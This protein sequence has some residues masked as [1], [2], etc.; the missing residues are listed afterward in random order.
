MTSIRLAALAVFAFVT[1][2]GWSCKHDKAE[3]RGFRTVWAIKPSLKFEICNMIGILIG[4]ETELRA[5]PQIHREWQAN[6]PVE[7]RAALQTI[8]RIIGPNWP[9]GP[10]LSLLWANLPEV[11]SLHTL[12]VNIRP[13]TAV[14]EALMASDYGSERNW[15]QWLELKPHVEVVVQ[16]LATTRFDSYWRARILPSLAGRIATLKQELQAY[17]LVGDIQRF[18]RD[19]T[20]ARDTITVYVLALA[21][22]HELRLRSQS[23]YTDAQFSARPLVRSFYQEM[24]H[25]YCDAL[26]DSVFR[27]EFAAL[28][29]DPF[30]QEAWRNTTNNGATANF[31]EFLKKEIVL[32][33]TLWLAE[34]RQLLTTVESGYAYEAGVVVRNYLRPKGPKVHAVAGVLYSYLE[35][36]LKIER[37]SYAGFIKD[38]F[39]TGRLQPGKIASRYEEFITTSLPEN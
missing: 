25:P 22:P 23:R 19:Y 14:R 3:P 10:R 31:S 5:H 27:E 32:A 24:L 30:V 29:S 18:L 36:G 2:F 4:R 7:V 12:L 17:D 16:Y 1:L 15:T 28:Q 39:A 35:S 37:V 38:L 20:F 9:P 13:D 33:A 8:D 34:R 11:D 21:R 6:L 26:V